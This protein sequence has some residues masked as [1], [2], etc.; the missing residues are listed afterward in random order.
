MIPA[1][2]SHA[3]TSDAPSRTE[4][5]THS[6]DN[7]ATPTS[8]DDGA[9]TPGGPVMVTTLVVAADWLSGGDDVVAAGVFNL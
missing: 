8:N 2:A 9:T 4:G 6:A 7:M 5:R 3:S 1:N